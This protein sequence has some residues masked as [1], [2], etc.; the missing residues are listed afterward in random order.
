M[1]LPMA[2]L[3]AA[4]LVM[5][6]ISMI[7]SIFKSRKLKK[8]MKAQT[9][10]LSAENAQRAQQ[11]NAMMQQTLGRTGAS[12]MGPSGINPTSAGIGTM[13]P[14]QLPGFC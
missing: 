7:G 11:L 14:G 5:Q 13:N 10:Q 8:Q 6:G 12:Y 9:A 1:P 3:V 4:P 2:A